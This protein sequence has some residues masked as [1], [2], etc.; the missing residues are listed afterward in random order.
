MTTP[1]FNPPR[2]RDAWATIRGYVYQVD[3]IIDR[4]L[5]LNPGEVLELERGEDIDLVHL[6]LSGS[7]EEQQR[8]LEQVKHRDTN[9]TL[10]SS[11]AINALASYYEHLHNNP[12][13]NLTFRYVTNSK[14]GKER[15]APL[16]LKKISALTAWDQLRN[17]TIGEDDRPELLRGLKSILE[18]ALRPAKFNKD[19]WEVWR[20]F[21]TTATEDDLFDFIS[22]VE[23]STLNP[24]PVNLERQTQQKL[25]DEG[26]AAS[27]D[28][29][30]L[31]YYKLFISV[32]RLL[33][34]SGIKRLS[35]D[36]LKINLATSIDQIEESIRV[37]L[38]VLLTK[39]EDRVINIEQTLS[40]QQQVVA[41]LDNKVC[42]L[43]SQVGMDA[44]ISHSIQTPFIDLPL[45]PNN[46]IKRQQ[47]V[48]DLI[49]ANRSKTWIGIHGDIACGKTLLA[50]LMSESLGVCKAWIRLRG[51]NSLQTSA[52]IDSAL[53]V[54]VGSAPFA[55][56]QSWANYICSK[57][58]SGDILVLDD[59]PRILDGD[60]LNEKLAMLAKACSI[61]NIKILSTSSHPFNVQF[62]TILGDQLAKID[63]P[64]F[65]DEEISELFKVNNSPQNFLTE[66]RLEFIRSVTRGHPSLIAAVIR[67]FASTE[68]VFSEATFRGLISGE[69]ADE[70][71]SQTQ[72]WLMATVHEPDSRDLLYRLNLVGSTFRDSDVSIIS[73]VNPSIQHPFEK[74]SSVLGLW[75][76][77]DS[78]DTYIISPLLNHLG[79]GNLTADTQINVHNELGESI[80]GKGQL[81]PVDI[82]KTV[83]HFCSAKQFNKAGQILAIAF[84]SIRSEDKKVLDY[85]LTDLWYGIPLPD[86]MELDTKLFL[87][88]TQIA[89][90]EKLGKNTEALLNELD[91]LM[92]EA[93]N[94][95]SF[96]VLSAAILCGLLRA[97]IDPDRANGYL[98]KALKLGAEKVL[99]EEFPIPLSST[100]WISLVGI[101]TQNHLRN[102]MSTIEQLVP[103]QREEAFNSLIAVEGCM[104][105]SN[106]LWLKEARKPVPKQNWRSIA[107]VTNELSVRAEA[108]GLELLWACSIRAQIIVYGEYIKDID[109]ALELATE[110]LTLASADQTV[111]FVI[112]EAVGLQLAYANKPKDATKWLLD[113]LKCDTDSYV[114][115]RIQV[116]LYL[117]KLV[118]PEDCIQSTVYTELAVEL[119]R[120]NEVVPETTLVKALGEHALSLWLKDGIRKAFQPWV[121][122]TERLINCKEDSTDWKSLFVVFGHVSGYLTSLACQGRPPQTIGNGE[123]YAAPQR[124]IFLNF[125]AEAA[126]F[127]NENKDWMV[128]THISKYAEAI[129]EYE[130]VPRWGLRAL[131][132]SHGCDSEIALLISTGLEALPHLIVENRFLE[133][134]SLSLDIGATF[135]ALKLETKSG[136]QPGEKLDINSILGS[137]PNDNWINVESNAVFFSVIPIFL[138]LAT[139]KYVDPERCRTLAKTVIDLLHQVSIKA[140]SSSLWTGAANVVEVVFVHEVSWKEILDKGN[141]YNNDLELGLKSLCY[142]GASLLAIP[143]HAIKLQISVFPLLYNQ[144]SSLKSLYRLIVIPFV[145]TFWSEKFK[146]ARFR[147]RAPAM[148]ELELEQALQLPP[149]RMA[150][151]IFKTIAPGLGAKLTDQ[152][153][154][155]I[156]EN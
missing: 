26:Y 34:N 125:S 8:I 156:N 10:R 79:S 52:S 46:L 134:V 108:I 143:E 119:A 60:S 45:V 6:A 55:S 122:A 147:F 17:G 73:N 58:D 101:N 155:W 112:K 133:V 85:G 91:R 62:K 88:A 67:Y 20:N 106:T 114:L 44:T 150:Q 47:T 89:A 43:A 30:E 100:I 132:M 99:N 51:L 48:C 4:W 118:G 110:S 38:K 36:D 129:G 86:G 128:A 71:F 16:S 83:S 23:W 98:L 137:K 41:Q 61:N 9:L 1:Q 82:M 68:W 135:Q 152:E 142:L 97:G 115:E 77:Q 126:T 3:L 33:S 11:E 123:E 35:S 40:S 18:E 7:Q 144:L 145:S 54:L 27:V 50:F 13:L 32:F 153:Q 2:E 59:L 28:V 154:I 70:L 103:E 64:R 117:S 121:E 29:A 74:I 138:R 148:V 49:T 136:N 93:T 65:S 25:I 14:V 12:G 5:Q 66:A 139:L 105:V 149:H 39:L 72:A 140:V 56:Y 127:Y 37:K 22:K 124:G 69:H 76:Q 107:E 146:A 87:R 90:C 81:G 151:G 104:M 94:E 95:E 141:E 131:E 130:Q 42:Q 78:P 80:I 21:I 57:L 24:S 111:Q 113:A 120:S 75:V 84:N 96:G 63:T 31:Q 53:T 15:N 92:E 102:W 116:L 109:R 19:S